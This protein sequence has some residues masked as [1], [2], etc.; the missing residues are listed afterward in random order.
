MG[1]ARVRLLLG[2]S[3]LVAAGSA[4]A[5]PTTYYFSSGSAHIT[6]TAGASLIVSETIALDGAWVTFDSAI[7][8][9]IGFSIT[10]PQ[11]API[12][13]L[14]PYGGF[15]TFVVESATVTPGTS[16]SNFAIAP[17]GPNTWGFLVGPVDVAG[18]YSASH[19]SGTPAPVSNAA[20]PFTGMSFLNGSINTDTLTFELLGVTLV[21]LNGAI[22]GETEDLIVKADITWSG[23]V[24][25][26]GTGIL[27]G[28]GLIA[29]A[30]RRRSTLTKNSREQFLGSRFNVT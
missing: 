6:A 29:L 5:T 27:L 21:E 10:A 14:T 9:V 28:S 13:M 4:E 12:S 26:P 1:R 22:L 17:T 7:P 11:S 20:V 3:L 16:Y 2:L 18:I 30:V 24:P 19:T 15:D 25:E 23:T 8:E